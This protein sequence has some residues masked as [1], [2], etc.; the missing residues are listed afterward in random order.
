MVTGDPRLSLEERYKNHGGY[1]SAVAKAAHA[2]KK[3]RLLLQ[4]D[5]QKYINEAASGDVLK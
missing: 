2:L 1:V 3:D 5:V 4:Q